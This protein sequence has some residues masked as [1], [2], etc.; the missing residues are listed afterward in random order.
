[1]KD[2][3][4]GLSAR[5]DTRLCGA[6][7]MLLMAQSRFKDVALLHCATSPPTAQSLAPC[8]LPSR[9]GLA[10]SE[11]VVT[12]PRRPALTAAATGASEQRAGRDEETAPGRTKKQPEERG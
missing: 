12:A 6:F 9:R 2:F 7:R 3:G 4:S 11:R 5:P 1:M 8:S 10:I